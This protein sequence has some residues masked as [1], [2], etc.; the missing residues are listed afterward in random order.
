[1]R[2]LFLVNNGQP[3]GANKSLRTLLRSLQRNHNVLLFSPFKNKFLDKHDDIS[4]INIPF[5]PSIFFY[6]LNIKYI[7]FPL[8][9]LV[10]LLVFPYMLLRT[11]KFK[12]D[13]IYSNSSVENMG[14]IL[15]LC[16]RTKHIIHVREFGWLDYSFIS[17]LGKTFKHKYLNSADGLI[18]N[19]NIVRDTVLPDR[20]V[21]SRIIYNGLEV[22]NY[23]YEKK[24]TSINTKERIEVG[25]IGYIQPNKGQL[26]ALEYMKP[27][28]LKNKKVFCSIYG[29]GNFKY[30]RKIQDFIIK[31]GFQDRILMKGY[32]KE[33]DL[34]YSTLDITLMFSKN[35]AFGR[36]TIESM[37]RGVPVLAYN[38]GGS[39]EIISNKID[40]YL[41]NNQSEFEKSFSCLIGDNKQYESIREA[42]V[43]KVKT[44]FP[45]QIYTKQIEEFITYIVKDKKL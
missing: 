6:R 16:T 11:L 31:N 27:I 13:L 4:N 10:N 29:S 20:K 36:V 15:A 42:A 22:D 32:V 26:E 39:I 2:I 1:M 24:D 5:F 7:I 25:I 38:G 33:M 34:L 28:L 14:K 21:D 17:I 19:S 8:L 35:E 3:Y 23:Q 12:P 45:E 37:L 30:T 44:M 18:F 43:N 40:G 41:F 9:Q